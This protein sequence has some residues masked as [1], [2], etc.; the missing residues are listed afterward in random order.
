MAE[1]KDSLGYISGFK[2]DVGLHKQGLNKMTTLSGAM[3]AFW[4][5]DDLR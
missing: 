5:P 2:T 4:N 1:F 3:V